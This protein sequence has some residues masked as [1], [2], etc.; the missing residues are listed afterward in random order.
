MGLE[1]VCNFMT[2]RGNRSRKQHGQERVRLKYLRGVGADHLLQLVHDKL[3][4][5]TLGAGH[6]ALGFRGYDVNGANGGAERHGSQLALH[7]G[8]IAEANG[9]ADCLGVLHAV[10]VYL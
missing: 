9:L 6:L 1:Q 3:A 8:G 2:D 4:D 7:L 10:S 5:N